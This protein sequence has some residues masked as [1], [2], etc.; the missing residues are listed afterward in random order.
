[1]RR[2][3]VVLALGATLLG[4]GAPAASAQVRDPNRRLRI[5]AAA[6]VPRA[7]ARWAY[8][9]PVTALGVG[10]YTGGLGYGGAGYG[11]PRRPGLW[12]R[13]LRGAGYGGLGYGACRLW[14]RRR[15][16]RGVLAGPYGAG[17][18]SGVGGYGGAPYGG[19]PA[20]LLRC[21]R[22]PTRQLDIRPS[23][24]TRTRRSRATRQIRRR[25]ATTIRTR[26]SSAAL[27][28]YTASNFYVCR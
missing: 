2:L 8:G 18:Y 3:M 6:T 19:F 22:A 21:S 13:W 1:M 11:G 5:R 28:T 10:A 24:T 12:W 23:A 20:M 15:S 25:T 17:G 9:V 7:M 4:A 27:N 16:D 14:R 26:C